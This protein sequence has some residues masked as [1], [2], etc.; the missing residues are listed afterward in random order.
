MGR[1]KAGKGEHSQRET[2]PVAAMPDTIDA[3]FI[4]PLLIL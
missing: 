3:I 4:S 1:S 2:S